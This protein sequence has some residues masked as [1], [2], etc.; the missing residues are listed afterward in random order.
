M[1]ELRGGES[2][3][4]RL[5]ISSGRARSALAVGGGEEGSLEWSASASQGTEAG[6]VLMGLATASAQ[7]GKRAARY[8]I[9]GAL[10]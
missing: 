10:L 4:A 5:A 9:E 1:H 8:P 2:G 6:A 3:L 7:S